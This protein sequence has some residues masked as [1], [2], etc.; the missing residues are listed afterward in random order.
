MEGLQ[1]VIQEIETDL[2]TV[3]KD[4]SLYEE[5][6]FSARV[7]ALD[8]IEVHILDRIESLLSVNSGHEAI[9][10]L[11][12]RAE[13]LKNALEAANERFLKKL[14]NNIATSN[15]TRADLRR[16]FATY[17]TE[18]DPGY[19]SYDTLDILICGLLQ[20]DSIPEEIREREPE[21]VPYQPTPARM[22]LE[23]L[24]HG[25]V[26]KDDV[27]YDLG[28]GLGRVPIL[29]N[30]LSGAG[31]KGVELEPAYCHYARQRVKCLHLSNVE[32]INADVRMA[33]YADGT[34]FYLYTPFMGRIL[35]DVLTR[36]AQEARK[37]TI[38]VFTY[39]PCTQ[40][41]AQQGWL[42]PLRYHGFEYELAVF[43]S[44]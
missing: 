18:N 39:G 25:H 23:L 42:Q 36:L 40:Q 37:R 17:A 3:Q 2:E 26:S 44:C 1:H 7:D 16:Q 21:M 20:I 35:A 11:Q 13:S 34:L 15:Y 27:L 43:Q 10:E 24:K 38:H 29:I 33:D 41:V 28:S 9:L 32:F 19:I 30:I 6:N 12:Q 5:A 8:T 31:T 14:R 22:I 4:A